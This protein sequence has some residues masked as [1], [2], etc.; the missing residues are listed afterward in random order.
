MSAV[1]KAGLSLK[2]SRMPEEV[3]ASRAIAMSSSARP[4]CGSLHVMRIE[5]ITSEMS[6]YSADT[7]LYTFICSSVAK[8]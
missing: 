6:F 8:F 2:N 5:S 3:S 4:H 7:S 1:V